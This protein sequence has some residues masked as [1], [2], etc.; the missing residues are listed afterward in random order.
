M[1][2]WY[3]WLKAL[4]IVAV[5]AWMAGMLYLPRLFVYH[6]Q[7]KPGSESSEMLKLMERRLLRYIMNPAMIAAFALGLWLALITD[8]FTT[9]GNGWLHAKLGLALIMVALHAILSRHRKAF[10]RDANT[11]SSRYFRLLNELPTVLII[12]IV[13]LAVVKPF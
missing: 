6:A 10:E 13:I 9:P 8:A 5:I 7:S 4:H 12:G 11:K 1:S 3:L 2:T